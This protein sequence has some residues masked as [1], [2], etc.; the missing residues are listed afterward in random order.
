M[1]PLDLKLR[2]TSLAVVHIL[3]LFTALHC[4]PLV[5][6]VPLWPLVTLV[7][8]NAWQDNV[9]LL[10][11]WHN[12]YEVCAPRR[13]LVLPKYC[14]LARQCCKGKSYL[15]YHG[16]VILFLSPTPTLTCY[17]HFGAAFVILTSCDSTTT[18][19]CSICNSRFNRVSHRGHVI[20]FLSPTPTCY[21]KFGAAF[22]ILVSSDSLSPQQ[23]HVSL[24][25]LQHL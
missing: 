20:F 6:R 13:I 4:L 3:L 8:K 24:T 5:C 15:F 7:N 12:W 18:C 23:L 10:S 21:F 9:W 2:Y 1:S 19:F 14:W 16:H 11:P 22:V 17:F 25:L